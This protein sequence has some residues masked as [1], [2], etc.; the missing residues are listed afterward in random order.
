MQVIA[1]CKKEGHRFQ[2]VAQKTHSSTIAQVKGQALTYKGKVKQAQRRGYPWMSTE[3]RLRVS[4]AHRLTIP[5][6]PKATF[7]S[8]PLR[9][10]SSVCAA[11]AD[12]AGFS[13]N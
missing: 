5:A 7:Q 2:R 1:K 6:L 8:W 11:H 9:S 4:I 13:L 12:R 10:C 3:M